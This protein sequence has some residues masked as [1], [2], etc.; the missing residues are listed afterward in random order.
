MMT[1]VDAMVAVA[2]T[3]TLVAAGVVAS[4]AQE[5]KAGYGGGKKPVT[6]TLT[7]GDDGFTTVGNGHTK[8]SLADFP[9]AKVFG[10]KYSS[11]G[12]VSFKGKPL[13]GDLGRID[14]IVRRPKDIVLKNGRGSGPLEMVALSLDSE[15][16]V[17]IG[18]KSYQIH[19][20]LSD[21]A[22]E[23]AGTGRIT[24]TMKG[25]DGGTFATTIHIRPKLVFTPEGGGEPVTI[26]CGAVACK[27]PPL[28]DK[29]FPWVMT[30]GPGKFDPAALKLATIKRGVAVGGEG[31][32]R[33]ETIGTSNFFPGVAANAARFSIVQTTRTGL[34]GIVVAI[35]AAE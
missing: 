23:G 10:A 18:G 16:P 17:S 6:V 22:K 2:L 30:G 33:F 27:E 9:I 11:S 24:V 14:T 5:S 34:H 28:T 35:L 19:V 12:N 8:V 15:Q 32:A 25:G 3:V 1:R 21:T 4:A 7:A 29:A 26:D 20:G 13:G 31:F